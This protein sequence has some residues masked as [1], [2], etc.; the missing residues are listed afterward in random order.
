MTIAKPTNEL[1]R[2]RFLTGTA[3]ALPLTYLNRA[4]AAGPVAP[5]P[6]PTPR[7][8]DNPLSG[9]APHK[10]V[11]SYKS[12]H[13]A[14]LS[15]RHLCAAA[16]RI[17]AEPDENPSSF[18][19]HAPLELMARFSLLP[20]VRPADREMARMQIV[21]SVAA[22]Q[23]E[24]KPTPLPTA[25]APFPDLA[26]AE[27]EMAAAHKAADSA[28]LEA[29]TLQLA[30]QAGNAAVVR[31]LTPVALPSLG[32]AAH[33]HIGLWLLLR[34]GGSGGDAQAAALLRN[35]VRMVASEPGAR[36]KSFSGMDL[37]I[38]KPARGS[39]DVAGEILTK[40]AT[41]PDIGKEETHG[42]RGLMEAAERS[43]VAD[44]LFGELMRTH[45]V[46]DDIDAG[47][48]AIAKVAAH[49]MLQ[50]DNLDAHRMTQP[51]AAFGL[52][53]YHPARKLALGSALVWITGY[54]AEG[55]K[56]RL[57]FDFQP[58]PAPP[59]MGLREALEAAPEVAA[60]RFWWSAPEEAGQAY[61]L[62]ATEA[63]VR[64]K[65]HF[66]KYTRACFDMAAL[67]PPDERLY[68]AA[69]AHKASKEIRNTPRS[70]L[71]ESLSG[72]RSG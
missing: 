38:A 41:A 19:L 66:V 39:V 49:I 43:G 34:H 12:R 17:V 22:Y 13:L 63:A 5:A 25:H 28:R 64:G 1:G 36:L 70:K 3:C 67:H 69:A 26:T 29:M 52:S 68:L 40:L 37:R 18:T 30:R 60:S 50:S 47:F 45:L 48:R 24:A 54:R 20:L 53:H 15:D 65:Q 59:G 58:P 4:H 14:D 35:A 31:I 55:D 23:E 10:V 27:R 62:L 72:K 57:D 56:S 2:R 11:Q 21:A 6:P 51:Q 32:A 46:D 8:A 42:I 9:I 7:P 16:T 44:R 33:A 71:T 61:E